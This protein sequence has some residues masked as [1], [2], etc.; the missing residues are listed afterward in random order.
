MQVLEVEKYAWIS[1]ICTKNAKQKK[2]NK[3]KII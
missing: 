3:K 2:N 1:E